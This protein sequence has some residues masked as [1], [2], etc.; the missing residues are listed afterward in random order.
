MTTRLIRV[1][2]E[3]AKKLKI[4]AAIKNIKM[5]QAANEAL[6]KYIEANGVQKYETPIP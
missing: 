6:Q 4:I 3:L 5:R 1:D 2:L